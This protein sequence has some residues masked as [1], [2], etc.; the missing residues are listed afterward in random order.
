MCHH[1]QL[2]FVFSVET[3]FHHVGQTGL[4]LLTSSDLPTSASQGAGIT[5]MSHCAQP[6][7]FLCEEEFLNTWLVSCT[8]LGAPF[9]G[10]LNS[11]ESCSLEM[12]SLP[13]RPALTEFENEH[14]TK[15]GVLLCCSGWSAE[16]RSRLT[17]TSTS[18]VQVILLPQPPKIWDKDLELNVCERDCLMYFF[19]NLLLLLLFWLRQSFT[20]SP[21]LECS[22]M[23]I[24]HCSR[25][26]LGSSDPPVSASQVAGTTDMS[27]KRQVEFHSCCPGWSAVAQSHYNLFLPDSSDAPASAF[28]VAGIT[29]MKAADGGSPRCTIWLISGLP[30]IAIT[31]HVGR[32]GDCGKR[33]LF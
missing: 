10:S 9:S 15:D 21:R 4:E 24:A 20:L 28:R 14:F 11:S 22:S 27:L 17:A 2:I 3:G 33:E 5:G 29:G 23:I 8:P 12:C 7:F 31:A 6:D 16:A 32:A 25:D 1:T 26:L 30:F 13:Q 18:W 19:L